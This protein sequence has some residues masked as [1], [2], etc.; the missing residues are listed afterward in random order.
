MRLSFGAVPEKYVPEKNRQN[1]KTCAKCIPNT[2]DSL[3]VGYDG[4][5]QTL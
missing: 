1:L 3:V 5:D 4:N 2:D